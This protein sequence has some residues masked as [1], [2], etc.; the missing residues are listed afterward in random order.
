M[1]NQMK[2]FLLVLLSIL[3]LGCLTED[4]AIYRGL[5]IVDGYPCG[6]I[7]FEAGAGHHRMIIQNI[8]LDYDYMLDGSR[9]IF[10][11]FIEYQGQSG[12]VP[13]MYMMVH[14]LDSDKKIIISENFPLMGQF[15]YKKNKFTAEFLFRQEYRYVTF[16]PV[17][18]R[19]V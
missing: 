11:G 8:I 19:V 7:D 5:P 3:T 16:S 15:G 12:I 17:L 10:D 4:K 18:P 9:V 6:E 13:D 14:F 1:R 2:T